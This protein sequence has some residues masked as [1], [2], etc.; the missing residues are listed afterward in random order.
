MSGLIT[1]II[2]NAL[3]NKKSISFTNLGSVGPGTTVMIPQNPVKGNGE[4]DFVFQIRGISGGDTKTASKLGLNAVVITAEAGGLGS[5][6][7]LAQFGSAN[8]INNGIAKVLGFLQKKYPDKKLTRGKLAVSWFSGGYAAGRNIL[9]ERNKIPGGIDAAISIDGMHDAPGTEG[10]KAY[11]DFAKEVAKDPNK[12]FVVI[13][14]AVNPGKYTSTTQSADYLLNQMNLQR[15]KIEQWNG[16][17]TK[18]AGQAELGGFKT[19]QLYDQEQPYV[20]KDES[21]K[22]RPN[23]PGKTSGWQHIDSL[24]WGL[25]NAFKELKW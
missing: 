17:G 12:K 10:A 23:V 15:Q 11:L 3:K 7:N 21:G 14:S 6:E 19:I 18:P 22:V 25:E 2:E 9:A 5:K 13:H 8:F 4:V 24:N 20:A 16:Q 1:N